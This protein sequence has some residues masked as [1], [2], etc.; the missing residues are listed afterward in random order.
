MIIEKRS[1]GRSGKPGKKVVSALTFEFIERGS[2]YDIDAYHA[3]IPVGHIRVRRDEH[4]PKN[5]DPHTPCYQVKYVEVVESMRRHGIATELY[6]VAAKVAFAEG[7]ALCSDTAVN[8][9]T[10][11]EAVWE[12]LRRKRVAYWEVPGEVE[13]NFDYGRYVIARSPRKGAKK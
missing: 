5:P 8:L 3:D 4:L 7:F 10:E 1:W 11:A 13:E 6:L 2:W 12:S 9:G